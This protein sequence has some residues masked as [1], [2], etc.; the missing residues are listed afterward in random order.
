MVYHGMYKGWLPVCGQL[1]GTQACKL[2]VTVHAKLTLGQQFQK[3][4][5][6]NKNIYTVSPE[7]TS[8][9]VFASVTFLKTK[10]SQQA[11]IVTQQVY[12][13]CASVEG[14]EKG[15]YVCT[16]YAYVNALRERMH[17]LILHAC[18]F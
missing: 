10:S 4:A 8:G 18:A 11:T 17:K 2:T 5:Y 12:P 3:D 16:G 1:L 13:A 9:T 14:V 7:L 6:T 15:L